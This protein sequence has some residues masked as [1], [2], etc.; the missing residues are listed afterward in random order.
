[1]TFADAVRA[2]RISY[3]TGRQSVEAVAFDADSLMTKA[4]LGL[5][6]ALTTDADTRACT[7]QL[8]RLALAESN[9]LEDALLEAIVLIRAQAASRAYFLEKWKDLAA[10]SNLGMPKDGQ[11]EV[12]F[13]IE[14][15]RS[16]SD[17]S[18]IFDGT[19]ALG[20]GCIAGLTVSVNA[21]LMTQS[22]DL[23]SAPGNTVILVIEP[24]RPG[25]RT[26]RALAVLGRAD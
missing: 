24:L 7:E 21:E 17:G 19:V 23:L 3:E 5:L 15:G 12:A 2:A 9:E 11:T 25:S 13:T 6:D 16:N 4:V 22:G 20:G 14:R 10:R 26:V 8:G 18:M 1:M